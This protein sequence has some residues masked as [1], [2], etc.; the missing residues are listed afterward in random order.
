MEALYTTTTMIYYNYTTTYT[1]FTY[2]NSFECTTILQGR[3][4]FL[5]PELDHQGKA[6]S[7]A[8]GESVIRSRGK[9][10]TQIVWVHVLVLIELFNL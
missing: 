8:Q 10:W 7:L 5:S 4:Y 6:K 2:M 1:A 9:T 3:I